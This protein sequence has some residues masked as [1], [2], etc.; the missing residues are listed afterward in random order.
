[1][2]KKL[3]VRFATSKDEQ[4]IFDFYKDNEHTFVAKREDDIWKERIASGAVTL[5]HDEDGKIVAS[6][7]TYPLTR[8]EAGGSETHAWSEIGSV[9]VAP[10]FLAVGLFKTLLSAEVLR[11]Y[12]LEPPEDRFIVEIINGNAHSRHVFLK[13]GATLLDMPPELVKKVEDTKKPESKGIPVEW[14]QLGVEVI[15]AFAQHL[16]N[17]EKNPKLIHKDTKE[18]YEL[19]FSRCALMTMFRDAL[20][21]VAGLD[22]G[23]AAKPNLKHGIKAFRDKFHP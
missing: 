11:A 15:P 8:D 12:L 23:D 19:D 5:I 22:Y 14:F 9:R 17:V 6:S 13:N 2:A 20:E 16:L 1:M 18:E 7:I 3:Y 21:D 10:E 4:D